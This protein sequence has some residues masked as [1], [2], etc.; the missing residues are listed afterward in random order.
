M[1]LCLKSLPVKEI[2]EKLRRAG[3]GLDS[4]KL[5]AMIEAGIFEGTIY[6]L[7]L[8][9]DNKKGCYI[10]FEKDLDRWIVEHSVEVSEAEMSDDV[11]WFAEQ[12]EAAS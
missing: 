9:E 12:T 4:P 5:I 7:K 2:M 6:R 10:A 11:R 3:F 1:P 8:K